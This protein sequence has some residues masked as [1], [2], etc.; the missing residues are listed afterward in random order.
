MK[1]V[2]PFFVDGSSLTWLWDWNKNMGPGLFTHDDEQPH[3]NAQFVPMQCVRRGD[4]RKRA[5]GRYDTAM[6]FNQDPLQEGWTEIMGYNEPD[7]FTSTGVSVPLDVK[8]AADRRAL[9]GWYWGGR[10]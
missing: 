10:R 7:L 8:V 2:Q 1:P 3:I 4:D 5:D 6:L 9:C